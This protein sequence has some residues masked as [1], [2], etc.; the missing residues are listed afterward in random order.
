[1]G[2]LLKVDRIS[3]LDQKNVLNCACMR[4]SLGQ[5]FSG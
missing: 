5:G 1:M 4:V 2:I 3:P